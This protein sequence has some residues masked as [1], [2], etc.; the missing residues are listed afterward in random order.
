MIKYIV[1]S[2][3]DIVLGQ[4]DI[5]LWFD[6]AYTPDPTVNHLAGAWHPYSGIITF[7]NLDSFEISIINVS[8]YYD[9]D[10]TKVVS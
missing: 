3:F 10:P 4:E 5:N 8:H 1:Q 6:I 7:Q 9:S 2:I